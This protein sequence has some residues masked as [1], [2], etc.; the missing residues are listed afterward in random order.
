[1]RSNISNIIKTGVRLIGFSSDEQSLDYVKLAKD[2]EGLAREEKADRE[3]L[4]RLERYME[5]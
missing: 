5:A 3:I 2:P 1:M 4:A